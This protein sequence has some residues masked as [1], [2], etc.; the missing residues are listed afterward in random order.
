MM[1]PVKKVVAQL[2]YKLARHCIRLIEQDE[3]GT[4]KGRCS[5][6]GCVDKKKLHR[7][8]RGLFK[9][10]NCGTTQNADVNGAGNQLSRYLRV[11]ELPS[12]SSRGCLAQP[13]MWQ[14]NNHLWEAVPC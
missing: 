13:T 5:L 4:S 7:V 9:C 3:R 10:E 11:D 14:W 1:F 2:S 6:C 8:H 12:I